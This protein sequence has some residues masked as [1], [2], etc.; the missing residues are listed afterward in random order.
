[1][2]AGNGQACA[3]NARRVADK[4]RCD[5]ERWSVLAR[6]L[7]IGQ[8]LS[9]AHSNAWLFSSEILAKWDSCDG[10]GRPTVGWSWRDG[11][12]GGSRG[13]KDARR[14]RIDA[15]RRGGRGHRLP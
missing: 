6:R 11:V 12:A 13:R 3:R 5:V 8:A 9:I 1:M 10:F 2:P 4:D 7:P 14:W 15:T